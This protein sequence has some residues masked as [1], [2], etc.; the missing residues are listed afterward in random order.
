MSRTIT[1][2]FDSRHEAEAARDR[3]HDS[4]IEAD[5]VRIID[6]QSGN[7]MGS[8]DASP[9]Q[10]GFWA[11][12]KDM[13]MP[14]EDRHTYGE[15]IRRGGYMLVA[16]VDEQEAD[17]AC[18]LLDQSSS[19]DFDQR[20][21]EWRQQG[22]ADYQ[23]DPQAGAFGRLSGDRDQ[24]SRMSRTDD[25][26]EEEHIPI[27]DEQLRVGKREV[28]RGSAR[29]RSYVREMPVH[30]QVN[31]REEHI[32]IERRPVDASRAGA[33]GGDVFQDREIELT[34]HAE[35]AVVSKEARVNEELV[36]RKRAEEHVENIDDSVRH[37]EV[38][39]DEGSSAFG[40]DR[41]RDRDRDRDQ[42]GARDDLERS[43]GGN[44]NRDDGLL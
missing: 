25:S 27:V 41:N 14:D 9:G 40:F 33:L 4:N 21:N 17:R 6:Q 1:A 18:Q 31:L 36:I 16:E 39:V 5:R 19:I 7:S 28:E 12:L 13:F 37:T 30:E 15:G 11:S 22:W 32:D 38:D 3:L 43:G 29:V 8:S 26:I 24:P 35:E 23:A 2:M 20:Q 10:E 42:D 44:R 34:E